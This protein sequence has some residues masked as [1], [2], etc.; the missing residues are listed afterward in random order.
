MNDRPPRSMRYVDSRGRKQTLTSEQAT[1]LDAGRRRFD[2][3]WGG[4]NSTLT[5]R[6]LEE[7]GLI[8]LWRNH[9]GA[10]PRWRVTSLT[11]LGEEVLTRWKERA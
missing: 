4:L 1:Y 5:V 6:L 9:S 3:G 2:A 11:K 7:R 10:Y 8:T